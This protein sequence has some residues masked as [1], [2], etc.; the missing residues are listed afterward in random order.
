MS[1]QLILQ[2]GGPF[3]CNDELDGRLLQG[4]HGYVAVLP[5]AVP[6]GAVTFTVHLVGSVASCVSEPATKLPLVTVRSL[7]VKVLALMA[8]LNL[9]V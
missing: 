6:V 9:S 5:T 1:G 3:V 2:G 4:I 8:S 7:A